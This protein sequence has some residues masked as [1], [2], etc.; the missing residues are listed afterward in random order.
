M[1]YQ[2]DPVRVPGDGPEHGDDR[3]RARRQHGDEDHAAGHH[4]GSHTARQQGAAQVD[5]GQEQAR[6]V[7]CH[8]WCITKQNFF[9]KFLSSIAL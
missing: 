5:Q 4:Q 9:C 3:V 7:L 8:C 1:L 6:Q 2:D